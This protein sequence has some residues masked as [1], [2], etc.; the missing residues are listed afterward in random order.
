LSQAINIII[1]IYLEDDRTMKVAL[2]I[3]MKKACGFEDKGGRGQWPS[4]K[5]PQC[6][7]VWSRVQTPGYVRTVT[8]HWGCVALP[9][10]FDLTK[11][12][13]GTTLWGVRAC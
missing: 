6:T 13:Y 9:V 12:Y 7:Q 2:L 8:I 11:G 3:K 4:G 5:R 1:C 10:A